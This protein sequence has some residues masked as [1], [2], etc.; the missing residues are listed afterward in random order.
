MSSLL[1]IDA[2]SIIHRSFHALPPLTRPGG[3]PAGALYGLSSILLKIIKEERPDFIAAFFDRPEATFR[4]AVFHEYKTQRPKAPDELV[5]QIIEARSIFSAFGIPVFE[6]AGFEADD[7]IGTC[8]E[9]FRSSPGLIIKIITGDLDMTQL[10]EDDSVVVYAMRKGVSDVAH[11]DEGAVK[12]K[13]GVLPSQIPAY[14]AL[15]GDASDNIPG[16]SGIGPKTAV[17]LLQKY[18]NIE[19]IASS[20]DDD[21]AA[22]KV[23]AQKDKALMFQS[24][25]AIIRN[26]PL[27]VHSIEDLRYRGL[28][29]EDVVSRFMRL[30]FKSLAARAE[31]ENSA[32]SAKSHKR[33]GEQ[34]TLL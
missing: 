14:K 4:E 25:A 16:V 8:A 29:I 12:E 24:V 15:A 34:Q 18:K 10:V 31:K 27:A 7:L 1:L 20:R 2:N 30:G 26:A 6:A 5:D 17:A 19:S 21:R 3:K 9:K 22:E 28:P 33:A 13:F 32:S 23:R 11:Y